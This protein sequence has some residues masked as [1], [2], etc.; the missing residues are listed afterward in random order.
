ML[1]PGELV[2]PKHMVWVLRPFLSGKIPGFAGGGWVPFATYEANLPAYNAYK[3]QMVAHQKRDDSFDQ[4]YA[5]IQS[6]V[7]TGT[8]AAI[9]STASCG[10]FLTSVSGAIANDTSAGGQKIATSLINKIGTAMTYAKSVSASAI[11][12]LNLANMTVGIDGGGGLAAPPGA[13]GYNAA[14]WNNAVANYANNAAPTPSVQD[15]MKTYLSTVQSFT[16]D[17]HT[18]TTQGLNKSLLSTDLHLRRTHAR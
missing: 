5:G 6:A 16:K 10:D 9:K 8:T 17:L 12:G 3:A 14:A 11:S 1:E 13:P 7:K 2:V 15:N 4:G 18:A